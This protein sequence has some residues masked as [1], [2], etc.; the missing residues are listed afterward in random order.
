[1]SKDS[2]VAVELS[3]N[4]KL[5]QEHETLKLSGVSETTLPVGHYIAMTLGKDA[6]RICRTAGTKDRFT[7]SQPNETDEVMY[8]QPNQIALGNVGIGE[9]KSIPVPAKFLK[10]PKGIFF[11]FDVVLGTN[12]RKYTNIEDGELTEDQVKRLKSE[13]IPA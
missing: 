7:A 12:N 11:A 13:T 3:H 1:M 10:Y 2:E 6:R 4:E 5:Y 9:E 8:F